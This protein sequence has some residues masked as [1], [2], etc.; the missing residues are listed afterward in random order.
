MCGRFYGTYGTA[1]RH[2]KRAHNILKGPIESPPPRTRET[3]GHTFIC[4]GPA[5][6]VELAEKQAAASSTPDDGN[7]DHN[8]EGGNH[9]G[10]SLG[11]SSHTANTPGTFGNISQDARVDSG[12]PSNTAIGRSKSRASETRPTA[13]TSRSSQVPEVPSLS[14]VCGVASGS[15]P[16]P[17]LFGA[18]QEKMTAVAY[19]PRAPPPGPD[20][21]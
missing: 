19:W 5:Y 6:L 21:L 13:T 2:Q 11:G 17:F 14:M 10:V 8:L 15:R 20:A 16:P 12:R 18:S 3:H 1:Q 9:N 4:L 7:L